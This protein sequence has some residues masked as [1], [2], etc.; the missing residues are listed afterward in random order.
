MTRQTQIKAAPRA[1]EL[2]SIETGNPQG[3]DLYP[4]NL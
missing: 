1:K 3:R 2:A 4:E